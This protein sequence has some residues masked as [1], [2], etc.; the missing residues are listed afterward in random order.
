MELLVSHI[1]YSGLRLPNSLRLIYLSGDWIPINLPGRIRAVSDNKEIRIISMGGATEASI[2][3]NIYEIG[4]DNDGIP[5]GWTSVPYGRPMRNQNMYVL[6][7][8]DHMNHCN[9]WVTGSIY[10]GGVGVARGYYLNPEKTAAQ[11]VKHP[12]TGEMLFRTGDLGRVRPEGLIEILGRE[13][14]QVK[15]NGFRIELGEIER[16]L[17]S[18]N[19]VKSSVLTVHKNALCAYVIL[20]DE[21]KVDESVIFNDLKSI[22]ED[23]LADYMIPKYFIRIQEFPLS[24]NGKVDKLKLPIPDALSATANSLTSDNSNRLFI[25]PTDKIE[26]TIRKAY[27]TVLTLN[28]DQISCHHN[29]FE[30][31]GNSISAIQLIH[32]LKKSKLAITIQNLF[33]HPTII[34]LSQLFKSNFENSFSKIKSLIQSFCLQQGSRSNFPIFTVNPAGASALCY[35]DLVDGLNSDNYL[36]GLDDGVILEDREFQFTSI[37]DVAIH[38]LQEI[39]FI[40]KRDLSID[41]LLDPHAR[42]TI[43]LMGWSYGGVICTEIAKLI[44]SNHSYISVDILILFDSALRSPNKLNTSVNS[45]E[46]INHLLS[47]DLSIDLVNRTKNHFNMCT[48]LLELY[49]SRPIESKP[50]SCEIWDIRPKQTNYNCGINAVKEITSGLI[51]EKLVD[52]NHWTMLFHENGKN[53]AEFLSNLFSKL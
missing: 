9:V 42:V 35:R 39:L 46:Q 19:I 17:Q 20:S 27:A 30:L 51:H 26:M 1:E 13:D 36:Y 21:L 11:F 24:A 37:E 8:N 15:V 12:K 43:I 48:K 18:H 7:D 40:L 14:S 50:L 29:F 44:K 5:L 31:G 38:C 33:Q 25:Y 3:S 23:K 34:S 47:N 28:E 10:I 52:G 41:I 45:D 32:K 16:T 6:N 53:V 2:W 22:C 4:I 49:H